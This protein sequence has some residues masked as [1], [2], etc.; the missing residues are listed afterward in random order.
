LILSLLGD[1]HLPANFGHLNSRFGLPEGKGDL[2]FGD[3]R[4]LSPG[5]PPYPNFV[6]KLTF[7]LAPFSGMRSERSTANPPALNSLSSLY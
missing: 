5:R 3:I 6:T 2:L 4:L 1:A 7:S